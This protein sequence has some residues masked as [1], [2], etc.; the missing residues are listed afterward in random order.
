MSCF[1]VANGKLKKI[2]I[3]IGIITVYEYFFAEKFTVADFTNSGWL[4]SGNNIP[5]S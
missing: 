1:F 2:F 4:F 5:V 3:I